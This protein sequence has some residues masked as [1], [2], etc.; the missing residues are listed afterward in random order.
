M[1]LF[2][3]DLAKALTKEEL[4][5]LK[6]ILENFSDNTVGDE[7]IEATALL[8][9]LSMNTEFRKSQLKER[10]NLI[11]LAARFMNSTYDADGNVVEALSTEEKQAIVDLLNKIRTL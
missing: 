5:L 7:S 1:G 10:L 4:E 9:R 2:T 3:V 8:M 6:K 11:L